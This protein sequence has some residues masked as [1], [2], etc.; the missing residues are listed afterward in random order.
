MMGRGPVWVTVIARVQLSN[1][2]NHS[3]ATSASDGARSRGWNILAPHSGALF[4][5]VQDTGPNG[6]MEDKTGWKT[7]AAGHAQCLNYRCLGAGLCDGGGV[8]WRG[9]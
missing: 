8:E 3:Q 1:G 2:N 5:K 9:G 6:S 7:E 4:C